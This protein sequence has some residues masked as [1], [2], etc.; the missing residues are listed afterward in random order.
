MTERIR[1][2]SIHKGAG[3]TVA[4][5]FGEDAIKDHRI[6]E[7][8]LLRA[9]M[10]VD[11]MTAAGIKPGKA[12]TADASKIL[13]TRLLSTAGAS[14]P[15]AA[16]ALTPEN[17]Q[18]ALTHYEKAAEKFEKKGAHK[19]AYAAWSSVFAL[20]NVGNPIQ[21]DVAARAAEHAW[22]CLLAAGSKAPG[23]K[24]AF[25]QLQ[26]RLLA[27]GGSREG[28]YDMVARFLGG[29]NGTLDCARANLLAMPAFLDALSPSSRSETGLAGLL[30][31]LAPWR[32]VGGSPSSWIADLSAAM[33]HIQ[34]IRDAAHWSI[35]DDVLMSFPALAAPCAKEPLCTVGRQE[36]FG[37]AGDLLWE[38]RSGPDASTTSFFAALGACPGDLAGRVRA[39]RNLCAEGR[40]VSGLASG[41]WHS[42]VMRLGLCGQGGDDV[43]RAGDA[44]LANAR[45]L[46]QLSSDNNLVIKVIDA[47]SRKAQDSEKLFSVVLDILGAGRAVNTGDPEAVGMLTVSAAGATVDGWLAP[48]EARAFVEQ[49]AQGWS[50][51]QDQNE[52]TKVVNASEHYLQGSVYSWG[53]PNDADEHSFLSLAKNQGITDA[54]TLTRGLSFLANIRTRDNTGVPEILQT[55]LDLRRLDYASFP[56]AFSEALNRYIEKTGNIQGLVNAINCIHEYDLR[57]THSDHLRTEIIRQ[58]SPKAAFLL[59]TE[60][61]EVYYPTTF[62]Q[63]T[64][65]LVAGLQGQDWVSWLRQLDSTGYTTQ[66]F[67]DNLAYYSLLN[68]ALPAA[69]LLFEH[70]ADPRFSGG[71]LDLANQYMPFVATAWPRL[72]AEQRGSMDSQLLAEAKEGDENAAYLI[73]YLFERNVAVSAAMKTFAQTLP[74]LVQS[75]P[76]VAAWRHDGVITAKCYFYPDEQWYETSIAELKRSDRGFVTDT[77]Y[78]RAHNLNAQMTTALKRQVA[79]GL[80]ER[81]IMTR[82]PNDDR[83]KTL[84]SDE[85]DIVVH[86]GHCFHLTETF[87]ALESVSSQHPKLLFGGS[88]WS[89]G[90]MSDDY[91]LK[92]YGEFPIV[93]DRDHGEGSV[94]DAVL[95]KIMDKTARDEAHAWSDFG[96]G[97]YEQQRGIVLPDDPAFLIRRWK[98]LFAAARQGQAPG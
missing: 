22:S 55:G 32:S 16:A 19:E 88:C 67:F 42:A 39:I 98:S 85:V 2:Y 54:Q 38:P 73:R 21:M 18:K 44:L 78:M 40:A 33:G 25:V 65:R 84:E 6:D 7:Q 60:S 64:D 26:D 77:E 69:P 95:L 4:K 61:K 10:T 50:Q 74:A 92:T 46:L 94:N 37:L 27:E 14:S 31:A 49:V 71:I 13:L 76:P 62:R 63:L 96:L 90:T 66:K 30:N 70:L 8:E 53:R 43:Q 5:V 75:K 9:G 56:Q 15:S 68:S 58:L 41:A 11:A 1:P 36:L 52:R 80:L 24:E 20:A 35:N 12:I 72:S 45:K 81:V 23:Q 3:E 91:F 79:G 47:A 17:L 83:K 48:A 93:A 97:V 57:T 87:P 34:S 86:R 51:I 28:F 82:D 59:L 89:F 29:P